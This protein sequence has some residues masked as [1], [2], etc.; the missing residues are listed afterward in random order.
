LIRAFH[1]KI[2]EYLLILKGDPLN[3]VSSAILAYY[4]Y[5]T[6]SFGA[7]IRR[8]LGLQRIKTYEDAFQVMFNL[9]L[10][11]NFRAKTYNTMVYGLSNIALREELKALAIDGAVDV[12]LEA[13]NKL[14][15]KKLVSA[16]L[17]YMLEEFHRIKSKVPKRPEYRITRNLKAIF[18]IITPTLKEVKAELTKVGT[19][20]SG[21]EDI[22]LWQIE[23][24]DYIV[25]YVE[26]LIYVLDLKNVSKEILKSFIS[27]V[28]GIIFWLKEDIEGLPVILRDLL[29]SLISDL[30]EMSFVGFLV[31]DDEMIDVDMEILSRLRKPYM[32]YV[33]DMMDALHNGVVFLLKWIS[34][35]RASEKA[36]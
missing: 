31:K 3:V 23:L 5:D 6:S 26:L 20:I 35:I 36:T 15:E 18:A 4:L 29:K 7:L 22:D 8:K 24:R 27:R 32:F 25:D 1:D 28:R 30:K 14:R 19:Y 9:M 34:K 13:F 16:M 17:T 11:K 2:L 21:R 10:N 33:Y 12:L